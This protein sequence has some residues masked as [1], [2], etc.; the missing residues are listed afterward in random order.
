MAEFF[1]YFSSPTKKK[2]KK[3]IYLGRGEVLIRRQENKQYYEVHQNLRSH[4][5]VMIYNVQYIPVHT[6]MGTA[7]N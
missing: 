2:R 4:L 1:F 5:Y 7:N 6:Y 3:D